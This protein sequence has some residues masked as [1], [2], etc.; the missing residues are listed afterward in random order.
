MLQ[1]ALPEKDWTPGQRE[2]MRGWNKLWKRDHHWEL[3][4]RWKTRQ[5]SRRYW[6]CLADIADCC[7][8]RPGDVERDPLRRIQAYSI[9]SNRLCAVNSAKVDA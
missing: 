5:V 3:I 6:V 2:Q 4:E 7:A 8:R 9:F 1:E